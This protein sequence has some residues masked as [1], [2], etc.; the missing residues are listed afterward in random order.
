[1]KLL[2]KDLPELVIG[3][4]FILTRKKLTLSG[5]IVECSSTLIRF[6]ENLTYSYYDWDEGVMV[7]GVKL[8]E[9]AL[10][11]T[12]D[13]NNRIWIHIVVEHNGFF[14]EYNLSEAK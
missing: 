7:H 1:M 3:K 5:E 9:G 10:S 4:P 12:Q 6:G 14:V 11:A 13:N 8:P 2:P